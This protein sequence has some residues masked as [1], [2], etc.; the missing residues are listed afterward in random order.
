MLGLSTDTGLIIRGLQGA[1]EAMKAP[2]QF[3]LDTPPA[4]RETLRERAARRAKTDRRP[5]R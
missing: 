4:R 1:Q 2:R 5:K 3:F